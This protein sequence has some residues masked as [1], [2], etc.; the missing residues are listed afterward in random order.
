MYDNHD[1]AVYVV[2][3]LEQAGVP[4]SDVSL[5]ANN[6]DTRYGTGGTG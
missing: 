6:T 3:A 2:Q 1:D 5:G 4:H